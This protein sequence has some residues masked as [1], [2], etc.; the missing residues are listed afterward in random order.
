MYSQNQLKT[1]SVCTV[2]PGGR[3]WAPAGMKVLRRGG[4]SV[5][6]TPSSM[7]QHLP[8]LKLL[9]RTG[10]R[11]QGSN[12]HD[13]HGLQDQGLPQLQLVCVS[14]FLA[15]IVNIYYYTVFRELKQSIQKI[16]R[17]R[18]TKDKDEKRKARL[19]RQSLDNFKSYLKMLFFNCFVL[20]M[21][22][23]SSLLCFMYSFYYV[24]R[25]FTLNFEKFKTKRKV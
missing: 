7:L 15:V 9:Q 8:L 24:K 16:R 5:S 19:M 13:Q 1:Q 21:M 14:Q 10:K 4:L 25:N 3:C 12:K 17:I 22:P 2:E 18:E 6:H 20:F 23:L 11:K